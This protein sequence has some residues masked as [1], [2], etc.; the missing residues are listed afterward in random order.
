MIK[1]AARASWFGLSFTAA[2]A[3]L[4]ASKGLFSK[5]LFAKGIDY[6]TITAVRALLALPMFAALGIWRGARLR[7]A[8]PRTLGLAALA[9]MLC[10]GFGSLIDFRALELIDISLE[11]ALLFTYPAFIVAWH[12]IRQRRLPRRSTVLAVGL[13]YLGT[14][15]VVGA[16]DAGLWQR[17]L[18]GSL[19]VMLCA[20]TTASYFLIGERCIPELG[21]SGFTIVAMTAAAAVV[22]L[23]F[24]MVHPIAILGDINPRQWLLLL[25]LSVLCM[26][27]PTILQA[28]GI[29]RVGAERGALAGTIGPPAAMTLGALLLDEHPTGWQILGTVIIVAGIL[30]VAR[31]TRSIA[32]QG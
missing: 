17:N 1:N 27:L 5:S 22:F 23:R 18:F 14:L 21:G 20:A 26:F 32:D 8:S 28:E 7:H 29:R 31:S 30:V 16:F 12:C 24:L 10:Y 13:T 9:G 11:R 4:F 3:I 6:Q 25:G 19:L 15:L 2:G